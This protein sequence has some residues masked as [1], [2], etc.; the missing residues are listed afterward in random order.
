MEYIAFKCD[1]CGCSIENDG[2]PLVVR[3]VVGAVP[4]AAPVLDVT[5]HPLPQ[6]I[7]DVLARPTQ[8]VHRCV[9][10]Y[11]WEYG[12]DLVDAEGAVV[13]RRGDHKTRE[14]FAAART[15]IMSRSSP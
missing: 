3:L 7:R 12:E 10:C 13:V 6:R 9:T 11:A 8:N 1:G 5:D 4:G 14:S 2:S 15:T